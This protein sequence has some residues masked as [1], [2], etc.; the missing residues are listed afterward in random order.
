MDGRRGLAE[1]SL[2]QRVRLSWLE[3]DVLFNLS[4]GSNGVFLCQHRYNSTSSIT[5]ADELFVRCVATDAV[6][7]LES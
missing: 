4:S 5:V 2:R 7:G 6:C 3:M 1:V